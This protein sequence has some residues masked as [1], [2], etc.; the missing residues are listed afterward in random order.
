MSSQDPADP[1]PPAEI[2]EE[3]P[4]APKPIATD[5]PTAPTTP[6]AAGLTKK[7]YEAM[8]KIVK[9][10]TEYKNEEYASSFLG[11]TDQAKCYYSGDEIAGAF[12][13]IVDK[14]NYP[15][16]W[17]IIKDPIAFSTIRVRSTGVWMLS[18][19]TY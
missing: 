13:R 19:L 1:A 3:D 9:Y 12:Q 16:Y 4:A 18:S 7:D 6:P 14:R 5:A 10:L 8:S 2:K 15:D 17:E 11:V